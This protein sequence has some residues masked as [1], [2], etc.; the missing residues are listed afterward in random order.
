MRQLPYPSPPTVQPRSPPP[1]YVGTLWDLPLREESAGKQA[2]A[3]GHG[4]E[5]E[6]A[7]DLGDTTG[8]CTA[9]LGV[10]GPAGTQRLN[11]DHT[12]CGASS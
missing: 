1:Y 9:E 4:A 6:K 11:P 5:G 7:P 3:C 10:A 12:G 8:A 2:L